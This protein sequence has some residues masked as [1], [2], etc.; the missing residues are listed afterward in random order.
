MS[1]DE[2]QG[3]AHA[4]KTFMAAAQRDIDR[5]SGDIKPAKRIWPTADGRE[6]LT[7]SARAKALRARLRRS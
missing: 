7:W 5:A 6:R 3:V 1:T 4:V 2:Y